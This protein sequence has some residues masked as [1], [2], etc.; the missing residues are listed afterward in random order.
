MSRRLTPRQ[1]LARRLAR[2]DRQVAALTEQADEAYSYDSGFD[3]GEFSGPAIYHRLD[4]EVDQACRRLGFRTLEDAEAHGLAARV[5]RVPDANHLT[6]G[7]P[8]SPYFVG[9]PAP[10]PRAGWR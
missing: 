7:E 9:R 2:L 1:W 5:P 8:V 3:A 4:R 10:R 6:P